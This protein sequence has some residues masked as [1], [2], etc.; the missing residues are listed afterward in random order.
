MKPKF[1]LS[2]NIRFLQS[3]FHICNSKV[4][5][6]G[7]WVLLPKMQ[8][9]RSEAK[10]TASLI[11]KQWHF[12]L[13]Y[14]SCAIINSF[15]HWPVILWAYIKFYL[16]CIITIL[17]RPIESSASYTSKTGYIKAPRKGQLLVL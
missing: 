17:P 4:N 2:L 3:C 10:K 15:S 1:I 14:V 7:F 11:P 9:L 6:L 16:Q 8:L 12:I 5:F 13:C